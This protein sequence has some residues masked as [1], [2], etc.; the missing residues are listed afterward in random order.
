MAT[1]SIERWQYGDFQTPLGLARKV[2]EVLKRN[3]SLSPDFVIEPTCGKG[4]F[5]LAS[6]E[7]FR[8]AAIFG[9][10]INTEYVS[11]A[12]ASLKGIS[13][14]NR[15]IVREADFFTTDWEKILSGL[16]G[17]ILIIGNPPWVT[18]SELSIL[19]SKNL[20][21]KSNF[22]NRRGIEAITGSG[23]FDIS[24]WMLLQHMNWLSKREGAIAFLCKQTVA[25]KI[26]RQAGRH[27][28]YGFSGHIYFIDAKAHFD[29][30]VEACL[31]VLT[32][33]AG[34]VDCKVYESLDSIEPSHII[35]ERDGHI[36]RDVTR[37][38]KWRH[39][40]GQDPRYIWRSGI[41]HDCAKVME[42]EPVRDG[43]ENGLG[44]FIRCEE[45]YIYPLLKGSDI[46]NGRIASYRKVLLV[47]QK[48][49]GEDTSRIKELAPMTWEYLIEHRDYLD[50][51][52]SAIYRNKPIFSIF[53]VGDYAFRQWKIAVSGFYKEL[54]FNLVGPL[55]GKTVVFD[56]TVNFLSFDTEEEAKFI[57][58]LITSEPALEFLGS[59][60]FRDEK[61]PITTEILRR[62]SLWEM[63][64]ELGEIIHYQGWNKT[65]ICESTGQMELGISEPLSRQPLF[66]PEVAAVREHTAE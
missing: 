15:V 24:E 29:A 66:E 31:F 17:Y 7:G 42:F 30:S 10:E 26:M 32:T 51:R 63:A 1:K 25:R 39:L 37:Y 14:T 33:D 60:V 64:R 50:K 34:T 2:V 18:S 16:H 35:G 22:Q 11:G 56:D 55:N 49:V 43:Y 48:K 9:F 8:N 36:V 4:A 47:T 12:N 54:K 44:E 65:R 5:V 21:E 46:G 57:Y 27:P 45:D 62:L 3:H 23:N 13:A 59:M 20:P 41:K 53:G 58:R 38:E 19:N 52:R 6:Y 28:E 61:R 40:R